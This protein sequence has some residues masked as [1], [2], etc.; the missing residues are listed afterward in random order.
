MNSFMR[1]STSRRNF[2]KIVAGAAI[3]S[4]LVPG[5]AAAESRPQQMIEKARI[6]VS[7]LLADENLPQLEAFIRE[8]KA[9]LVVPEL[10]KGGLI[11]GGEGGTGVLLVRG[12]DGVWSYPVFYNMGGASFGAQVGGQVSQLIVTIMREKGL[13]ALLKTKATAGVDFSVAAANQGVGYEARTGAAIDADMYAFSRNQGLF[14]GGALE[15]NVFV[16]RKDWNDLFY[17]VD[18]TTNE[19][20]DG[21]FPRPQADRLRAV[22]P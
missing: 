15:G 16:P 22:L 20:I 8:A 18:A 11:I 4:T 9:V 14:L 1:P 7:N 13:D 19:I 2:S 12:P 5:I 17:E 3:S 10:I 6:A 21:R